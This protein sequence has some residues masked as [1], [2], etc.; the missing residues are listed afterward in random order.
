MVIEQALADHAHA[1]QPDQLLVHAAP[2][3]FADD[4]GKL[5]GGGTDL[6]AHQRVERGGGLDHLPRHQPPVPRHGAF[7]EDAEQEG[8]DERGEPLL[9]GRTVRDP[10]VRRIF[11]V[12]VTISVAQHLRIKTLLVA[13]M[14]MH[15][16]DVGPGP[17]TDVAHRRGVKAVRGE[18]L[19]GGL[20]ELGAG[21]GLVGR[22]SWVW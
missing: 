13:E 7:G 22:K 15:R 19:G 20:E 3:Q 4:A 12:G 2:E 18:N 8:A 6:L 16:R 9:G 10:E 11:F 5:L 17:Q 1:A 14:V 21:P